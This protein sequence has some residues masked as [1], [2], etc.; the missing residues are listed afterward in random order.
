MAGISKYY[1]KEGDVQG[2]I[3]MFWQWFIDNEHRFRGLEK[4]D[5]DQALSFLEELIGQMQPFNPY[6]KALAGPDNN[7]NYELIIT[8]DGDIALFTEVEKL[9]AAAPP[10]PN[11]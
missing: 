11:W 7:G 9:V 5:S 4:N 3:T 2:A 10:V 6:L 8:S 1:R